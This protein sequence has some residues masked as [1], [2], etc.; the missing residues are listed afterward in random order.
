MQVFAKRSPGPTGFASELAFKA[1]CDYRTGGTGTP[2]FAVAANF[3]RYATYT[4]LYDSDGLTEAGLP[5]DREPYESLVKTV[6]AWT[7]PDALTTR[8]YEQNA[9]HLTGHARAVPPMSAAAPTSRQ[10]A[11]A[12][13]GLAGVVLREAEGR[14]SV[15][16][17]GTVRC[18]QSRAY[19]VRARPLWPPGPSGRRA[20]TGRVNTLRA[21]CAHGPGYGGPLH[22]RKGYAGAG[23]GSGFSGA[24]GST[25]PSPLWATAPG[26]L[27]GGRR[28]PGRRPP[29]RRARRRR[30][31]RGWHRSARRSAVGPDPAE[32]NHVVEVGAVVPGAGRRLARVR[33]ACRR[34]PGPRGAGAGTPPR[35]GRVVQ[36]PVRVRA[37]VDQ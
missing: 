30:R 16:L 33:G 13:G 3:R 10:R 22:L 8:D 2:V 18:V 17:E 6:L 35:P 26:R 11:A 25:G 32:P 1:G 21:R 24:S 29:W 27:R 31:R 15:T 36:R 34:R 23:A 20:H 7:G 28:R 37:Q 5:L 9:F 4:V 14:L 12:P 19:V